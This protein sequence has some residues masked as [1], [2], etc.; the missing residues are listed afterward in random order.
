MSKHERLFTYT[1]IA[2]RA[3]V[4]LNLAFGV[5]IAALL[6]ISLV[7]PSWFARAM[8]GPGADAGLVIPG[9]T[10]IMVIGLAGIPL[11]HLVLTRLDRLVATVAEGDPFTPANARRLLV[12]ARSLLGIEALH[13]GIGLVSAAGSILGLPLDMDWSPSLDG[14][15]MVLLVY[16]L[17]RVFETGTRLRADLEGTV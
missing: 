3:V 5:G 13:L 6:A 4:P 10:L 16:V 15:L 17:A 12:V 7:N 8:A 11:V 9:M 14:W 2:L 1:G